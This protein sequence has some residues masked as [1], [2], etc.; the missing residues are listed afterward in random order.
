MTRTPRHEPLNGQIVDEAAEWFAEFSTG[1][2]DASARRAFDTWLRKSPEH[3]RA[4][5]EMFPL[6]EDAACVGAK[7]PAAEEL[8]ELARS[9][10]NVLPLKVEPSDQESGTGSAAVRERRAG[11]IRGHHALAAGVLLAVAAIC[12]WAY[13]QRG[14]RATGIGEQRVIVLPDGS[15]IELNARSKVR[16]RF[17]ETERRVELLAGEALFHV[18]KDKQRPFIVASGDTQVRA[19]GTSFDVHRKRSGITVTVVE[20]HVTVHTA[21][22]GA[23]VL[24]AGERLTVTPTIVTKP[25]PADVASAI[26]WRERRLVFSSTP[27][28]EVADEFNRYNE[29]QLIVSPALDGFNISAVFSAADIPSLLRFLRAQPGIV[30]EE[31]EREIRISGPGN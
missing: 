27:L 3:V 15:D 17:T 23:G 8:I 9:A 12:G 6:W 1:E 26:A 16:L 21:S 13:S 18:A 7:E 10:D 28:V 31:S 4:Y 29:R 2:L 14:I 25:A 22:A 30:V 20:G 24:G 5:L 19:V 11:A